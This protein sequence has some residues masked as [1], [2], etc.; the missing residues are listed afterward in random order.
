RTSPGSRPTP[1]MA[2]SRSRPAFISASRYIAWWARWKPPTPT[3][4]MP[5]RRSL[6]TWSGTPTRPAAAR[7]DRAEACRAVMAH[8]SWWRM[9]VN[10]T[11]PMVRQLSIARSSDE[12][13]ARPPYSSQEGADA[14]GEFGGQHD[15][16][17]HARTGR[18]DH[19]L[20]MIAGRGRRDHAG[21]A[22]LVGTHADDAVLH[23]RVPD[24]AGEVQQDPAGLGDDAGLARPAP[25]LRG[26]AGPQ[27]LGP[28]RP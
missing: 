7:S 2:Q 18:S 15:V 22:Q 19:G 1:Q 8:P 24:P 23:R 27:G 3:W 4:T 6:S 5:I 17:D 14:V 10:R 26:D 28:G 20:G 25:L 11:I 12:G 9:R 21:A 13:S 16:V